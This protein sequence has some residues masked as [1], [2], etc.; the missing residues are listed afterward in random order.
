MM[1]I[2]WPLVLAG[3][4]SV[5]SEQLMGLLV[6]ASAGLLFIGISI[7]LLYEKVGPNR[8]YGFRTRK[9][10]SD[11]DIWYK[12]NK[13]MAKD[14][15]ILGCLQVLFNLALIVLPINIPPFLCAGNMLILIGGVAIILIRSLLYLRKL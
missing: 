6:F 12:A 1:R 7:P 10:L 4:T 8:L 13:Y 11:K 3:A 5:E 2:F 9:T 14:F 15:L